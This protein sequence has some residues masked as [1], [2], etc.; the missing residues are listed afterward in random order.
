MVGCQGQLW[1]WG[2][3]VSSRVWGSGFGAQVRSSGMGFTSRVGSGIG[4]R[5]RGSWSGLRV[6]VR[7]LRLKLWVL[8]SR[9]QSQGSGLAQGFSS[10]V[11]V[12]GSGPRLAV[13]LAPW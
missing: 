5:G 6:R 4:A 3:G 9:T 1:G 2:L 13:G 10:G 7:G 8:W 11:Q 12:W